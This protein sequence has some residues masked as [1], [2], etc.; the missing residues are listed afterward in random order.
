MKDKFDALDALLMFLEVP[1]I[2]TL[3]KRLHFMALKS[4]GE[5]YDDVG[6]CGEKGQCFKDDCF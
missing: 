5:K 1:Y 6:G 4:K 2:I 3:R